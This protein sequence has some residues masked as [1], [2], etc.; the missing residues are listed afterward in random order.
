MVYY[1]CMPVVRESVTSLG[2]SRVGVI[3]GFTNNRTLNTAS[4]ARERKIGSAR[5]GHYNEGNLLVP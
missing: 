3:Y 5:A 2:G 1:L 4:H